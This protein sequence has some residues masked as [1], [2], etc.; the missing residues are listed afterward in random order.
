MHCKIC[1][2]KSSANDSLQAILSPLPVSF[3][4]VLMKRGQAML[5]YQS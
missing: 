4:K 3:N 1:I 5:F 2:P